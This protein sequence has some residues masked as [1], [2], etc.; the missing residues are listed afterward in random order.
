M[1]QTED[2]AGAAAE[3]AEPE[4]DALTGLY[5]GKAFIEKAGAFIAGRPDT[6]LCMISLDIDHFTLYNQ[7]YGRD[8][9]DRYSNTWPRRCGISRSATT[10]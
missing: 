5:T 10:A 4:R 3:A 7:L 9:G 6:A 1:E 2:K 8:E